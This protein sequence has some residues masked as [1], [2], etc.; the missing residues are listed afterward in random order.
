MYGKAYLGY[1]NSRMYEHAWHAQRILAAY[2]HSCSQCPT[3][4]W[5]P[6]SFRTYRALLEIQFQFWRSILNADD[7]YNMLTPHLGHNATLEL[8]LAHLWSEGCVF[9]AWMQMCLH[10][11]WC[12][13]GCSWYTALGNA[14]YSLS[15]V[16]KYLIDLRLCNTSSQLL[17]T[18]TFQSLVM[19]WTS[20]LRTTL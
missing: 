14:Q 6:P 2:S 5:V 11:D 10:T 4:N 16:L 19:T 18:Y 12:W 20:D 13:S 17:G 15:C 8:Y 1:S 9:I 7:T 3:S